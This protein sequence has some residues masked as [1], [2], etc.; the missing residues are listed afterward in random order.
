M[1]F[2]FGR[3]LNVSIVEIH[4]CEKKRVKS[5]TLSEVKWSQLPEGSGVNGQ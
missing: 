2:E 4:S 1:F 5:R 3:S